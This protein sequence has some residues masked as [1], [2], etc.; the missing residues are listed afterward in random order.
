MKFPLFVAFA[1]LLAVACPA[2]A[3]T[4]K[5]TGPDQFTIRAGDVLQITVWKEEGLDQEVVVLPDGTVTF[6]LVGTIQAQGYTPAHLQMNIKNMLANMIP[7]AAVAVMVKAPLGHVVSVLGQ[8]A[9]PGDIVMGRALS[10]M[11]ALSQAGGLTPFASEGKIIVIRVEN[12]EKR[13]LSIPYD[14]IASGRALDKDIALKP[15]D[16]VFVPT[17]G[18]L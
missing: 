11:Q 18:L 12:G 14:D 5:D 7:D 9:K 10:V 13:S 4:A 3:E 2:Y 1:L 8:V 16:V 17:A 15:G 6:P